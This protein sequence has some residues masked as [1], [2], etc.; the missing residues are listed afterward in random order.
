MSGAAPKGRGKGSRGG[1]R[2]GGGGEGG[3]RGGRGGKRGGG[4]AKGKAGSRGRSKNQAPA[5]DDI[6][7]D[8][9]PTVGEEEEGAVGG[10]GPGPGPDPDLVDRDEMEQGG[11]HEEEE[12]EEPQGGENL[13]L[14]VDEDAV[15]EPEKQRVENLIYQFY[16]SHPWFY[17]KK[18]DEYRNNRLRNKQL[19]GLCEQL[20]GD[21]TRKLF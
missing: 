5:V 16:E 10:G 2:G 4:A 18:Y 6:L 14:P 13:N 19:M 20:G 9:G 12:D 17:D 11:G 15:W 21:W 8:Q 7:P 3:G 1:G